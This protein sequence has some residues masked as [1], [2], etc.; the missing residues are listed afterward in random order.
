LKKAGWEQYQVKRA[1]NI[2]AL[3]IFD[4]VGSLEKYSSKLKRLAFVGQAIPGNVRF[5]F[6]ALALHE[7]RSK[8]DATIWR[9]PGNCLAVKQCWF[10][11]FHSHIGGNVSDYFCT[12][13][14][15]YTLLWMVGYLMRYFSFDTSRMIQDI[16]DLMEGQ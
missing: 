5:A 13:T 12:S 2:A 9:S 15:H 16:L 7:H 3:G 8:F 4:T 11:G 1:C 6:Q 10:A 14:H